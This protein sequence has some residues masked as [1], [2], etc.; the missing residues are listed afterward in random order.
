[1]AQWN[2]GFSRINTEHTSMV[3]IVGG[4]AEQGYNGPG[5]LSVAITIYVITKTEIARAMPLNWH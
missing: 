5:K 4:T 2:G 3:M 1:M